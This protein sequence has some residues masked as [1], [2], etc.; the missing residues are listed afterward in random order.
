MS[1]DDIQIGARWSAAIAAQ[2][3]ATGFGIIC[4]TA[5]NLAAPWLMFEAGALS[6]AVK[7]DSRVCPYLFRIDRSVVQGP[8]AQFQSAIADELGTLK[9]LSSI[10]ASL[11]EG[12]RSE[13]D[14][15][16][17]LN[18]L[19]PEFENMLKDVPLNSAGAE[20]HRSSESM[21]EELPQLV[22]QLTW[23]CRV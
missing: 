4:L 14:L 18:A 9:L 5:E 8:L 16:K 19:W 7:K 2:L 21:M 6:K 12:K 13:A 11:D 22:G 17:L 23:E 1:E 3:D 20:P 15:R 10:N